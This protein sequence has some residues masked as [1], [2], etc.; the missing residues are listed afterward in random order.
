[1]P[2]RVEKS[3]LRACACWRNSTVEVQHLAVGERQVVLQ[4]R[5]FVAGGR[6]GPGSREGCRRLRM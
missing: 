4:D 1:M 3:S 6:G 5:Q 2:S